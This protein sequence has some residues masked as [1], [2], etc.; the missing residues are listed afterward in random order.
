MSEV[1]Q[2]TQTLEQSLNKTDLGHTIFENRKLLL[3]L[4]I[5]IL[6]STVG[7]VIWKQA[8]HSSQ[9]EAAI[10][11]FEFQSKVWTEAK[12]SKISTDDLMKS[13]K[14]LPSDVKNAPLMLPLAF[15]MS[16][17][18]YEQNKLAEADEVLAPF[19]SGKSSA[20]SAT[21]VAFQRSVVLE[22]LGK[23]DEAIAIL[24]KAAQN[25]DAVL[26]SKLFLEIGRLALAKG[27]MAKAKTNLEYVI[28]D[29]PNDE[30]AKL[31]KLYLSEVK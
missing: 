17:F 6:L 9:Q 16:K 8:A 22:S 24:E 15:E 4:L 11:V 21:F 2:P 28:S 19:E 14:E 23:S 20:I 26:K 29:F 13:Y 27:D 1:V 31:A 10:K 12:A 3:G 30:Y 18:L 25:K 7:F 5:V